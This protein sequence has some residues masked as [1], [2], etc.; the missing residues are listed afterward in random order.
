MCVKEFI[1]YNCGH[2]ALP[3]LRGCPIASQS[4]HFPY[5]RY[6]AER[7]IPVPENC[8]SCA[9]VV[10][11]QRTLANEGS[12]REM[13]Y[14]L[15][16]E[17]CVFDSEKGSCETRFD[18][19]IEREGGS[20]GRQIQHAGYERVLVPGQMQIEASVWNAGRSESGAGVATMRRKVLKS[21]KS[22]REIEEA[23]ARVEARFAA[24]NV[25]SSRRAANEGALCSAGQTYVAAPDRP[26][27]DPEPHTQQSL[28]GGTS[29]LRVETERRVSY[30]NSM[31][32]SGPGQL[33]SSGASS[34][35]FGFQ[36]QPGN[37][38][39]GYQ[40]GNETA[41]HEPLLETTNLNS[42]KV[43]SDSGRQ[44]DA[45]RLLG[46]RKG[47]VQNYIGTTKYYPGEEQY[48]GASLDEMIANVKY[49]PE[50]VVP[51]GP[52]DKQERSVQFR[53]AAQQFSSQ[54]P[55]SNFPGPALGTNAPALADFRGSQSTL[56]EEI[57]T[58]ARRPEPHAPPTR[59]LRSDQH[60]VFDGINEYYPLNRPYR[61]PA[62]VS[63]DMANTGYT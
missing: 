4:P 39:I 8:P 26:D 33:S 53:G 44:L 10:W 51:R 29:G 18:I 56:P 58:S 38:Y 36:A 59:P 14:R 1:G 30:H 5:C 19:D 16:R 24:I 7:P 21:R 41:G 42:A 3:T 27:N 63:S 49:K 43:E 37:A 46:E 40:F 52:K 20:G 61:G 35:H 48:R 23:I 2:C 54:I 50:G 12:H 62:I 11:N 45:A 9:R 47:G 17:E 22:S 57:S 32:K 55:P 15:G 25:E 13:H 31:A 34:P 6:P 60:P 28:L